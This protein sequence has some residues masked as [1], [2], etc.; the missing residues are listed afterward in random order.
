LSDGR[1]PLDLDALFAHLQPD[2][3][4]RAPVPPQTKIGHVHLHVANLDEAMRFYEGV[5]GFDNMGLM[6]A[7]RMGMVSAGGYHHHIGF[8]TWQ[9]EGASPPPLDAIG[10]R[11]FTIHMPDTAALVLIATIPSKRPSSDDLRWQTWRPERPNEV[12]GDNLQ[13]NRLVLGILLC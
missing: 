12:A 11:W 4:I 6:T 10:L 7:F 3:D 2:D 13:S 8:N 5:L 9:G 1:E